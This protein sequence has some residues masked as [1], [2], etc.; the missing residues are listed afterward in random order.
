[1]GREVEIAMSD[2]LQLVVVSLKLKPQMNTDET[3]QKELKAAN[4]RYA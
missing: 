2:M 4:V 3:D 1:M